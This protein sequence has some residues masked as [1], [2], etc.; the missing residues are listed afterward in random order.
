MRRIAAL[1]VVFLFGPVLA[2]DSIQTILDSKALQ[3]EYNPVLVSFLLDEGKA[4]LPQKQQ[5]LALDQQLAGF[6][7]SV[8]VKPSENVA[9][10]VATLAGALLGGD[11]GDATADA[12][13]EVWSEW[14]DAAFVLLR[15]GYKT[16]VAPFF[17]K[18][19]RQLPVRIASG[20]LR[21][22]AGL[23]RSRERDDA[24]HGVAGERQAV[25]GDKRGVANP[26]RCRGR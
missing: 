18:L 14:V 11:V 19:R 15:A 23:V 20:P 25:R 17:R 9:A 6:K 3:A 21:D 7:E 16:E 4:K 2:A 13:A 10:Q 1:A 5:K 24:S 12:A 8:D 22:G 26:R